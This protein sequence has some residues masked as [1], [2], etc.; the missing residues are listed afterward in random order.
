[1]SATSAS[2]GR[3][4]G[5][6]FFRRLTD[7]LFNP[8]GRRHMARGIKP[9]HAQVAGFQLD[10]QVEVA[11]ARIRRA[12]H[13]RPRWIGKA[14]L[15]RERAPQHKLDAR[16]RQRVVEPPED[17]YQVLGRL[18]VSCR[19]LG[20]SELEEN[21]RLGVRGRFGKRPAEVGDRGLGDAARECVRGREAERIDDPGLPRRRRREQVRGHAL[22]GRSGREQEFRRPQ[23]HPSALG[24]R[25]VLVHR[26]PDDR[27]RIGEHFT[28][29]KDAGGRQRVRNPAGLVG[30]DAGESRG[31]RNRRLVE[32]RDGL[33]ESDGLGREPRQ[34]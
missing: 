20:L 12:V 28:L 8:L 18:G 2:I 24:W 10:E 29:G 1:V 14:P 25:Q 6:S 13:E 11:A 5:A 4:P 15:T 34:P 19:H 27:M 32:H 22:G 23:L 31:I 17:C 30:M 21:L 26:R 16:A 3:W 7:E 33:C 9:R